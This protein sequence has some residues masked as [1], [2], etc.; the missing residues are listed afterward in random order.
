M[1]ISHKDYYKIALPFIISTVT[2]PLLGAVDT[3]VIGQLGIAELIAGVAVGTVI[4]NTLYW[5][6][7]FF[8]VSTTGQSAMALGRGDQSLLA[9]SLMRPFVLAASVGLV[10]IVL[11]S[12]LWQ[13]ALWIIEP[14]ADVAQQAEIY[15]SILIFGAPFV[16]LN[17]TVIGWL[18]GVAINLLFD[19]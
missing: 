7:G 18:M 2:Q 13:G 3:A 11:Q 15:F 14:E 10:F 4:M 19:D 16:L 8:R 17:Y 1:T 5:L 9:S 6:F 12:L